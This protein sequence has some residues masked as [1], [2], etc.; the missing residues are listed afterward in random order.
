MA[1]D[2]L[3]IETGR[4]YTSDC[5]GNVYK[6]VQDITNFKPSSNPNQAMA[7]ACIMYVL[8][9][10][11]CI[12]YTGIVEVQLYCLYIQKPPVHTTCYS[13]HSPGK[14]QGCA[15]FLLGRCRIQLY[16]GLLRTPKGV[17][18]ISRYRRM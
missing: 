17:C 5:N 6:F 11:F 3:V 4:M 16:P 12:Y 14:P 13:W 2:V 10:V 1:L 9:Q 15:V 18:W 7:I 8:V